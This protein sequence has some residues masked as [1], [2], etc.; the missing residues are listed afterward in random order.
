MVS[1]VHSNIRFLNIKVNG[2]GDMLKNLGV[3]FAAAT[4]T[5]FIE[6]CG[7]IHVTQ[8][9]EEAKHELPLAT[10]NRLTELLVAT[11]LTL[12]RVD[13]HTDVFRAD[14]YRACEYGMAR[15]GFRRRDST[16]GSR[17]SKVESGNRTQNRCGTVT[18]N[19][20]RLQE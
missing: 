18:D 13:K 15:H 14:T 5:A 3:D 2:K 1:G 8:I 10:L 16:A 19:V 6:T 9:L 17:S 4:H 12:A 11:R 7:W 20:Q